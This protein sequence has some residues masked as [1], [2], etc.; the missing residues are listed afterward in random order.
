MS[1]EF[2][3]NI[4]KNKLELEIISFVHGKGI[5]ARFLLKTWNLFTITIYYSV[6]ND[7]IY[8]NIGF[9]GPVIKLNQ[10]LL[11]RTVFIIFVGQLI[12][13]FQLLRLGLVS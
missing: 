11:D 3:I 9:L 7:E 2:S 12:L 5:G 1:C 8:T 4:K 10:I 6:G 13:Q